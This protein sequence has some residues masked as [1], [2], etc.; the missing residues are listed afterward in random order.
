[1]DLTLWA[2]GAMTELTNAEISTNHV[3]QAETPT[4]GFSCIM[5]LLVS[6]NGTESTWALFLVLSCWTNV[7][8]SVQVKGPR[9]P[10]REFLLGQFWATPVAILAGFQPTIEFLFETRVI[11]LLIKK[12]WKETWRDVENMSQERSFVGQPPKFSRTGAHGP[13]FNA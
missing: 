5:K 1:M 4:R 8:F 11:K 10:F 13:T 3:R 7:S 6:V 9:W 2:N 12:M